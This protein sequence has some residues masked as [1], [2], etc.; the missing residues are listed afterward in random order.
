MYTS[1]CEK[2]MSV[3]NWTNHFQR[4]QEGRVYPHQNGIWTLQNG[5]AKPKAINRPRSVSVKR[6]TR[7]TKPSPPKKRIKTVPKLKPQQSKRKPQRKQSQKKKT[8]TV[9]RK[10]V[11]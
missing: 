8:L 3:E 10:T 6:K 9:K 2:I 11:F 5:E 7:V 4:M 1:L